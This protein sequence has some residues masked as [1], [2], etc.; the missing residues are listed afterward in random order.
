[1]SRRQINPPAVGWTQYNRGMKVKTS[2]TLSEDLLKMVDRA[3]RKGE[4]RSRVLE[5]LVREALAARA[6]QAADL[7]DQDL[8]NA[9][10]DALNAEAEDVLRYQVDL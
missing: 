1:M 6:R 9:H 8:I 7:R 3:G 5:R 2:V 4:A 10:A